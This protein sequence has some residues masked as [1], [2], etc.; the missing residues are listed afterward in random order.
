MAAKL[1]TTGQI[2]DA[3]TVNKV[4]EC[5]SYE[6]SD[7]TKY[8]GKKICVDEWGRIVWISDGRSEPE[9]LQLDEII[10]K[11]KWVLKPKLVDF[12][13]ALSTIE[14]GGQVTF[15]FNG[16][17]I[18]MSREFNLSTFKPILKSDVTWADL[19]GGKFSIED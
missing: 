11:A 5:S 2:I 3:L 13:T 16:K 7:S 4:G 17:S 1:Y 9:V 8:I 18:K 10:R 14:S 19:L 15:Y 6:G 12:S